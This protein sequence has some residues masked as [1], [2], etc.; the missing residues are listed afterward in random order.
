[1][2]KFSK[3]DLLC[4]MCHRVLK[5]PVNLP[6]Q[7]TICHAHLKSPKDGLIS[8]ET[9]REE[10]VVKNI[11]CKVT[12]LAKKALDAEYHLSPEEKELKR[13]IHEMLLEFQRLRNQLDKEQNQFEMQSHDHFARDQEQN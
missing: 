3:S 1:M 5:D 13:D 8:C 7:C 2:V 9:C 12:K 11:Q 4:Q 6:C 10:F